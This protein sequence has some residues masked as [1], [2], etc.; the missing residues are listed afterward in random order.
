MMAADSAQLHL[1]HALQAI[2]QALNTQLL[3]WH[4]GDLLRTTTRTR[5]AML[6][7]SSEHWQT[8]VHSLIV[9]PKMAL[10]TECICAD[11]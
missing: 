2:I 7:A 6:S 11:R 3:F 10:T 9:P 5:M 1:H 8:R 4:N